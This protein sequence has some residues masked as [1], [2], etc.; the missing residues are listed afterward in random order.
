MGDNPVLRVARPTNDLEGLARMYRDGLGMEEMGRFDDHD[1]FDGV[2][3]GHPSAPY[4]LEF[5]CKRGHAVGPAPSQDH[6]LVLYLPDG[7]EWQSAC[8]RMAAAGF[9]EVRAFNPYWDR[10]GKTYE[11]PEG[12]RVVLQNGAWSR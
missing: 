3:L 2:I 5:T 9:C 12:Y 7:E 8:I 1:G 4:H 6:L 10:S 11:D